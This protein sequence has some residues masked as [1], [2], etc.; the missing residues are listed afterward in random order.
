DYLF[1]S[2][3]SYGAKVPAV[4]LTVPFT[5]NT[6]PFTETTPSYLDWIELP[7]MRLPG[8]G[9]VNRGDIV[10]FN[11]PEGDTVY[12]QNRNASYY[13]YLRAQ[14]KQ[15]NS[16]FRNQ[17]IENDEIVVHPVDKEDNY[18]KRCV[19]VA[20]DKLEIKNG[21]LFINGQ[22]SA[23]PPNA[24]FSWSFYRTF[25]SQS[26]AEQFDLFLKSKGFG[27]GLQMASADD[28][29]HNF[30][31]T[32]NAERLEELKSIVGDVVPNRMKPGANEQ[33]DVYPHSPVDFPWNRDNFGP[34]QIPKKGMTVPLTLKDLPLWRRVIEVYEGHNLKVSGGSILIDGKPATKYT[35][36]MDYYF[37]MG[38]NRHNSLDSR[39]WGFVPETHIIGK[40]VFIWMSKGEHSGL[41]TDRMFSFVGQNGPGKSYLLWFVIGIAGI[42]G[43][44]Y[45]RRKRKASS[46]PAK[47]AQKK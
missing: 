30:A 38:V 44:N 11:F 33:D 42:T 46:A 41:R 27:D 7:Y 24:Q 1:V 3:M 4:P 28:T 9:S 16:N 21:D 23:L 2:K 31:V 36:A 37:M 26:E 39:Y 43:F 22:S 13:A 5:H 15:G 10:V 25:S 6:M 29:L 45:F 20:G 47:P 35:F 17:L 34:L 18:V 12:K 8:F 32:S 14:E 19:A 40:P